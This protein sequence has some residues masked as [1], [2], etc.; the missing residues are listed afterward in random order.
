MDFLLVVGVL[1]QHGFGWEGG[2]G[3]EGVRREHR[4][5]DSPW[6]LGLLCLSESLLL[7]LG[8]RGVLNAHVYPTVIDRSRTDGSCVEG[9]RVFQM[10]LILNLWVGY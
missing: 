2:L 3:W 8:E 10:G 5:P 6:F 7:P 4:L 1:W 9:A